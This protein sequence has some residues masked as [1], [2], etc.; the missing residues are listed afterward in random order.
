[1]DAQPDPDDLQATDEAAMAEIRGVAKV[2]EDFR[3]EFFD[4]IRTDTENELAQLE[5]DG[6]DPARG[7]GRGPHWMKDG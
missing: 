4:K 1:M 2:I 7:R 6:Y 5:A 3:A